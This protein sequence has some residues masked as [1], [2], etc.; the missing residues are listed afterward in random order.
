MEVAAC[1]EC[2]GRIGGRYHTL[3]ASNRNAVDMD[4]LAVQAGA[5]R[6]YAWRVR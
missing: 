1:P 2:G 6:E 4:E 3:D 5:R